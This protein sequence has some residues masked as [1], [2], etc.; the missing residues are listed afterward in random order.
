[1]MRACGYDAD[2][3]GVCAGVGG[4]NTLFSVYPDK[5][6]ALFEAFL[7]LRAIAFNN[8]SIKHT[9]QGVQDMVSLSAIQTAGRFKKNPKVGRYI[10]KKYT[11][12]YGVLS[13]SHDGHWQFHLNKVAAELFKPGIKCSIAFN[14]EYRDADGLLHSLEVVLEA[15]KKKETAFS[16]H[17]QANPIDLKSTRRH[18]KPIKWDD[19]PRETPQEYRPILNMLTV[20]DIIQMFSSSYS[21]QDILPGKVSQQD[22][23]IISDVFL[24]SAEEVKAQIQGA[25]LQALS[26]DREA[27][28]SQL[29]ALKNKLALSKASFTILIFQASDKIAIHYDAKDK[30]WTLNMPKS[31]R[32]LSFKKTS[33]L[34]QA[35][36]KEIPASQAQELHCQIELK[37]SALLQQ[38]M[39]IIAT[40]A[41]AGNDKKI[42]QYFTRLREK[43]LTSCSNISIQL[44][45]SEHLIEVSY[46]KQLGQW[47][48]KDANLLTSISPLACSNELALAIAI[49]KAFTFWELGYETDGQRKEASA[50]GFS[51]FQVN[52]ICDSDNHVA[53]RKVV[54]AGFVDRIEVT[55][56]HINRSSYNES[57]ILHAIASIKSPSQ[58]EV[59]FTKHHFKH[60]NSF[61]QKGKSPLMLAVI[62]NNVELAKALLKAGADPRLHPAGSIPILMLAVH[63]QNEAMIHLLLEYKADI[64]ATNSK[65]VTAL[66]TAAMN[67]QPDLLKL[68]IKNGATLGTC[69]DKG[70][71]ALCLAIIRG[72]LDIVKILLKEGLNPCAFSS[73]ELNPWFLAVINGQTAIVEYLLDYGI[74]IDSFDS[75]Q[76]CNA[77]MQAIMH[78][79]Q[80]LL[81]TLIKSQADLSMKDNNGLDAL[82]IA[83]IHGNQEA[84]SLLLEKGRLDKLHYPGPFN[85]FVHASVNGRGAIFQMLMEHPTSAQF[86]DNF[87][88]YFVIALKQGH[89]AICETILSHCDDE[90]KKQLL[91]EGLAHVNGDLIFQ[92]A[93]TRWLLE[94]GADPQSLSKKMNSFLHQLARAQEIPRK[95]L[96]YYLNVL[97][98]LDPRDCQ[99]LLQVKNQYAKD[100]IA[101]AALYGHLP[102]IKALVKRGALIEESHLQKAVASC[103]LE[104]VQYLLKQHASESPQRLLELARELAL[105]ENYADQP[106]T[107]AMH[108]FLCQ[109]C[110]NQR[111]SISSQ[112]LDL[113]H[114]QVRINPDLKTPRQNYHHVLIESEVG[115]EQLL[116]NLEDAMRDYIRHK[117]MPGKKDIAQAVIIFAKSA[118]EDPSYTLSQKQAIFTTIYCGLKRYI[119]AHIAKNIERKKIGHTAIKAFV[120]NFESRLGFD[121]SSPSLDPIKEK[122]Q[123]CID[124]F[125]L[126]LNANCH[127][128][129]R[130]ANTAFKRHGLGLV[131]Q[132]HNAYANK[133]ILG[134]S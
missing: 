90:E 59:F 55:S 105:D 86:R 60:I 58:L 101:Y 32:P 102:L 75:E 67:N 30:V 24:D 81:K 62:Y 128:R 29:Q 133:D 39:N 21:N 40:N 96:R 17:L 114:Q 28:L 49:R 42:A 87:S 38:R 104:I 130:G 120:D 37:D 79:H 126:Y 18:L 15:Q 116:E 48:L 78:G 84:V 76:G 74:D 31:S 36:R 111:V 77:L 1:M 11:N 80:A 94:Q 64:N 47:M 56:K 100:A 8:T 66:M 20:F 9:L 110:V 95:D 117:K 119:D 19:I 107:Q 132:H 89:L 115:V 12:K 65:G 108:A 123:G 71:N 70:L 129:F 34:A 69:N 109:Y 50:K 16:I 23:D 113:M 125:S 43:V 73:P 82:E 27:L 83:V 122:Y 106:Q 112:D 6:Q 68:L 88:K 124:D 93:Q 51:V 99:Q 127:G 118:R 52:I 134:Q 26:D 4:L 131:I 14:I 22:V 98:R 33:T 5:T 72:H 41:I 35:L 91:D 92:P 45:S 61:N 13:I 25:I 3:G 103:D 53:K 44:R 2:E 63:Q 85:P 10:A 57:N 54:K 97:D 46:D 121:V 7:Y